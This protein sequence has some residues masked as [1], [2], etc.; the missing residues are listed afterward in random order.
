MKI[1]RIILHIVNVPERHWWWSDDV[2]GQPSHQRAEHGVAEVETDQGL[3]GLTLVG[4]FTAFRDLVG[5]GRPP[6][7][8]GPRQRPHAECF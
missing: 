8:L 2:Y 6:S 3:T 5:T 7:Q 4:R 1:T